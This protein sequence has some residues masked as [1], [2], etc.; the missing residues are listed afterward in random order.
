MF[1]ICLIVFFSCTGSHGRQSVATHIKDV[2]LVNPSGATLDSR[3]KTPEGFARV[4]E[5]Q[6]SFAAYLRETKLRPNG[7][8]VHF[9][10]GRIKPDNGVYVAVEQT[11]IGKRDLLQC[12]DAVMCQRA[13]YQY[14]THQQEQIGF[15]FTSGF[16]ADYSKW[17]E[18]YRVAVSGN[19]ATWVKSAQPA[20]T[21]NSFREYLDVIFAYCGTLSLSKELKSVSYADLQPGDVLIIGGSP[22]HAELVMD[23]A[24]NKDGKKIY[25]LSQGYMPAQDIHILANLNNTA[26]S[27]WYELNAQDKVIHTPEFNFGTNDVKRFASE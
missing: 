11:D 1:L 3:I 7:T 4:N 6:G 5:K 21:W 16:R 17:K 2:S 22:G 8:L 13:L 27:P 14:D 26:I 25:M 10:D 12:A 19:D 24:Q 20:N 9:Y 23:M 15:T 18:G